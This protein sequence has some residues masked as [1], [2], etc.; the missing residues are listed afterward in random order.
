MNR[1]DIPLTR[2]HFLALAGL[3]AGSL[4]L[5]CAVNPVTGKQQLMLVSESDEKQID[6]VNSPHQFSAD[7]GPVQDRQLSRY[8]AG[9]G[10]AVSTATHRTNLPYRFVPLNAGQHRYHPGDPPGTWERG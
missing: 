4:I 8:V 6:R 2:R 10:A 9:V 5:G 7:Y 1:P 3:S